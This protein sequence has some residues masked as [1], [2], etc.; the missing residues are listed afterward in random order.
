VGGKK[1][2]TRERQ[3]ET[4]ALLKEWTILDVFLNCVE[5]NV[6]QLVPKCPMLFRNM[7][8]L[9]Q[10]ETRVL[11]KEWTILEASLNSVEQKLLQVVPKWRMLFRN[12]ESLGSFFSSS[13]RC[14]SLGGWYEIQCAFLARRRAAEASLT[15]QRVGGGEGGGASLFIEEISSS[16]CMVTNE[17]EL[18]ALLR[19]VLQKANV[20][21]R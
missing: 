11:L 6:L 1:K 9:G 16:L 2:W 13:T 12:L 10:L 21:S 8:S 20:A 18:L 5:Q 3:L 7:E 17:R 19:V 15:L 4:T 14:L